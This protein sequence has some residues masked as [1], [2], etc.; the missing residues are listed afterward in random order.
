M[1]PMPSEDQVLGGLYGL[2]VGDA[3]G[4]PYEFTDATRLPTP[5]LI[6]MKPPVGFLRAHPTAPF[7]AWSDDGAQALCLLASLLHCG[8]LD[9]GDFARRLVNWYEHGYMAVDS[10]VFDVGIQTSTA[11]SA[12]KN[13]VP[14]EQ[15]APAT[16]FS[17]GNGSLMR[18][19]PLA[20][21][22]AGTDEELIADAMRQSTPTH[23]HARSQ[24]SCA[25]YC[26]WARAILR[27]QDDAWGHATRVLQQF[28]ERDPLWRTELERHIQPSRL[29]GG[30][31]SGYVVDC[32]HSARWAL[33]EST[34]ERA[35]KRAIS[36]GDDTD[37]TAA[38]TGGI[39][40]VRFGLGNIPE[41]WLSA[42]SSRSL[43]EPLAQSLLAHLRAVAS[44]RTA[45]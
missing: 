32:L 28:A 34:F 14:L 9:L 22:H 41:R 42:L 21:W 20:L 13:G 11:L 5:E 36:L 31:G 29:P 6:E 44:K 15:A 18:T 16:E 17:N 4:V 40:G 3:L 26:L 30:A 8:S 45:G 12:I 43:V 19:L 27:D 35:V 23:P 39:A 38:V 2:L 7:G 10:L 25:L 33:E 37:T 1:N 24:L